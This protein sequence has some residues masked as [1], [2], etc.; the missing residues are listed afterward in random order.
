MPPLLDKGSATVVGL[1]LNRALVGA[2]VQQTSLLD[3]ARSAAKHTTTLDEV[4]LAN[5]LVG[6]RLVHNRSLVG[7]VRSWDRCAN[8]VVLVSLLLDDRLHN[9]VNVVVHNLAHSL[10]LVNHAAVRGSLSE[11][12]LGVAGHGAHKSSVLVRVGMHLTDSGCWHHTAVDLLSKVLR[13]EHWLNVVLNVVLVN[14]VFTLT[15]ELLD[16]MAVVHVARDRGEVLHVLIN[17]ASSHVDTRVHARRLSHVARAAEGVRLR[18]WHSRNVGSTQRL[19]VW[20]TGTSLTH[21][22]R[23]N[24]LHTRRTGLVVVVVWHHVRELLL[25][26]AQEALTVVLSVVLSTLN[27]ILGLVGLALRLISVEY[28]L[29][30]V[31]HN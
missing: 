23:L 9:V 8:A 21:Y 7:D 28:L 4:L 17:V 15:K 20:H 1:T 6:S 5:R 31:A 10:T 22:V 3:R 12:V 14:V 2:K 18:L 24:A 16:L 27:G 29:N 11:G 30:D 26:L 13:L 25:A 19:G